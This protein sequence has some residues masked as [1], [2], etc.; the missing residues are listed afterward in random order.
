MQGAIEYILRGLS[1][2]SN[3]NIYENKL[4]AGHE[5]NSDDM[6]HYYS[7]YN[8]SKRIM[9]KISQSCRIRLNYNHITSTSESNSNEIS[10]VAIKQMVN[11]NLMHLLLS[12]KVILDQS[13]ESYHFV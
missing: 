8:D 2:D 3:D 13:F 6:H 12:H 9:Y 10:D 7:C 5:A 11:V 4:V 1:V